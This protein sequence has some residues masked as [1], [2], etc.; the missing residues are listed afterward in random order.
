MHAT[1]KNMHAF[2]EPEFRETTL[3]T[4][5]TIH[6]PSYSSNFENFCKCKCVK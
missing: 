4:I 2:I 5:K 3:K 6:V 1:I